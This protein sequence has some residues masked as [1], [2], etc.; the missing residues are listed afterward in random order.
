[1]PDPLFEIVQISATSRAAVTSAA[2]A[3]REHFV[4]PI[5]A[6]LDKG[7]AAVDAAIAKAGETRGNLAIAAAQRNAIVN[8]ALREAETA[9][10]QSWAEAERRSNE[11][12]AALW[13]AA[14]EDQPRGANS[15]EAK[16]DLELALTSAED[17]QAELTRLLDE[18]LEKGDG[19]VVRL[20]TGAEAYL[21]LRKAYGPTI[22]ET[23]FGVLKHRAVARLDKV[24]TKPAQRDA[25]QLLQRLDGPSGSLTAALVAG[26]TL[27]SLRLGEL[28]RQVELKLAGRDLV[29]ERR[30]A[31]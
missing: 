14:F 27:T 9:T 16:R 30:G 7:A 13:N 8:Q 2:G 3:Y 10:Q 11:L 19:T 15:S 21:Q 5:F 26:N 25:I 4:N 20:V 31:K 29:A 24:A 23:A 6:E 18:A 17:V 22:A 28:R 12:R 1:M